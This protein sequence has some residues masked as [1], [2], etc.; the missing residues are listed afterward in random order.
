[1]K[2][3]ALFGFVFVGITACSTTAEQ[4]TIKKVGLANPASEYCLVQGGKL[5][6]KNEVSGQASY[7]TLP[8]GQEVEE[9]ELFRANQKCDTDKVTTLLGQAALTDAQIKQISQASIVRRVSPGQPVT[10]DYRANRVTVVI[11]SQ[12]KKIMQASCG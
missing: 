8:S 11:D 2:A 12:H 9:W 10:M 4:T 5:Q 6:I 3:I 1:M 7:C